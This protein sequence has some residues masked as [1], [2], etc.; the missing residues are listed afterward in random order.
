MND[1]QRSHR[2]AAIQNLGKAQ[3]ALKLHYFRDALQ[4]AESA[5]AHIKDV[6]W[7][8]GAE[9]ADAVSPGAVEA[10]GPI[11]AKPE[12]RFL[13]PHE[14]DAL[15]AARA[16]CADLESDESWSLVRARYTRV[17]EE[18]APKLMA[19]ARHVL[20]LCGVSESGGRG[21]EGT[22]ASGT[23]PWSQ[24]NREA[25]VESCRPPDSL[26]PY[27]RVNTAAEERAELQRMDR[28]QDGDL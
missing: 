16:E 19:A 22:P 15:D 8:G 3:R 20:V 5:V 11:E 12:R 23:V 7:A 6:Q 28:R 13:M 4:A 10:P 27:D 9:A 26:R 18:A 17:L 25:G 2:D 1:L 21:G 24:A 14:L